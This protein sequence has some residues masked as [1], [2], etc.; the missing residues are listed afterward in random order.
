MLNDSLLVEVE[1]SDSDG[2]MATIWLMSIEYGTGASEHAA[3]ADLFSSLGEYR[4]SLETREDRLSEPALSDLQK[5]RKL[6]RRDTP[7]EIP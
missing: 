1:S 6:I 4:E 2:F 3:I 7:S 5:L